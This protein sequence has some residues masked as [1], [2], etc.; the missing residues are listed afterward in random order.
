MYNL[1]EHK[2]KIIYY[3]DI[4]DGKEPLGKKCLVYPPVTSGL[5]LAT[6]VLNL[7]VMTILSFPRC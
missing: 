7:R 4:L 1:K 3:N 6:G 5:L 2:H